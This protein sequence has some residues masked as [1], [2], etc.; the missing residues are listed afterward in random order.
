M[1]VSMKQ[2]RYIPCVFFQKPQ[3]TASTIEF[4][5]GGGGCCGF[6]FFWGLQ[7]THPCWH[8]YEL[9]LWGAKLWVDT[10]FDAHDVL[11]SVSN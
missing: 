5:V 2:Y 3:S 9:E 11:Q 4:R 8:L 10:H 7:A 6:A 1:Y